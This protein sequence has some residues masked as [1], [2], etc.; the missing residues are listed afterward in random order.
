MRYQLSFF[1]QYGQFYVAD[2]DAVH[3]GA[4]PDFWSAEAHHHRLAGTV[5]FL[6][7]AI[8][9]DDDTANVEVFVSDTRPAMDA[10]AHADHVVEASIQIN[11]G[12][13]QFLDCPM[14]SVQLEIPLSVGSYRLQ[15]FSFQLDSAYAEV[16]QDHYCIVIWP[17]AFAPKNVYKQW[18]ANN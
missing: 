11:S 8:E 14:G 1:T 13:L 17:G 2:S 9:N 7:I 6:G 12:V 4:S 16:P 10:S 3:A 5:D 18:I 15:I